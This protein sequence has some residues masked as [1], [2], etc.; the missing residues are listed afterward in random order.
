MVGQIFAKD[1]NGKLL[2]KTDLI[3]KEDIDSHGFLV[4]MARLKGFVLS[5]FFLI[6]MLLAAALIWWSVLLDKRRHGSKVRRH[7]EKRK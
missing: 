7:Y 4:F 1:K 2:A 3:V 5:P 6:L